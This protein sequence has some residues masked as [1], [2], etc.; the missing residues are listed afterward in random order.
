[1]NQNLRPF[2]TVFLSIITLLVF[3]FFGNRLSYAWIKKYDLLADVKNKIATQS[4]KN[5]AIAKA[6]FITQKNDSLNKNSLRTVL[7]NCIVDYS[8]NVD[9]SSALQI[10]FKALQSCKSNGGKAR[11]AYFGDSMIEGDLITQDLRNLLQ[12]EFGGNGVGFVPMTSI[13]AGFRQTITHSFSEDWTDLTFLKPDTNKLHKP[14]ITGHT[15]F[16]RLVNMLDS[17]N[18][19][20]SWVRYR[21]GKYFQRITFFD[22]IKLFYGYGS[23]KN[24]LVAE[25][26]GAKTTKRL[27]G[28]DVVNE[29][30]VNDKFHLSDLKLTFSTAKKMPVYGVS[31][32]GDSGVVLDNFSF[33]GNSGL[34][35]TCIPQSILKGL[36]KKIDYKL[37][38]VH[39]GLNVA[40][41]KMTDYS[42]Y[43]KG[44]Y[45]T[46]NYIKEAFPNAS[47]LLVSVSDK[48]YKENG[49]YITSPAIPAL[50]AAQQ[51]VAQK[52]HI[53]FWNLYEAM[54]GY[55]TMV[56]WVQGD[57]VYANKDYTHPNFRGASKIAKLFYNHIMDQYKVFES[58][59]MQAIGNA[60][61]AL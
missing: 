24:W 26:H 14:A 1:M 56:N 8:L 2:L 41:D 34:A 21:P 43:E 58:P 42:W 20:K 46:I 10:F 37:I 35:L 4:P 50:V 32:E 28:A 30:V 59:R 57:T 5:I 29:L 53:A 44:M 52:T 19:E 13:T 17:V 15:Y 39:Y 25:S 27:N 54:G 9:S 45:R 51:R 18:C 23:D 31:F 11:I 61:A 55:N 48:S 6:N 7:N 38:I 33:R 60:S 3:P 22:K 16:P 47:I 12:T 36:N 49:E 40:N